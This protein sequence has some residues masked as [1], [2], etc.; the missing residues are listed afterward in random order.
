MYLS[1][2]MKNILVILSVSVLAGCATPA[3]VEQMSVSLPITQTNSALKNSVGVIEVTGGRETNPMWTSQV[4]SDAFRRALEQ[5]LENAGMFSK[6][7]AGSKYQLTAD[8]TRLDQPMMGFD[9]TVTSTVRYSFIETQTR[10]EVYAKVIQISY[11]AK[12]SD[13]FVGTQRLKLANEGAVKANIQGLINDLIAL[14]LG[15][16]K[17][18]VQHPIQWS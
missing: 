7:V 2:T 16:F 15:S 1:Q 12:M 18:Q 8:L 11:T 4:S 13:A 10:K 6:I 17:S 3:A 14:K 9:M 5:S